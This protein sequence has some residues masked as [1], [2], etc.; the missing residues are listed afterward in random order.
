MSIRYMKDK[1]TA[2]KRRKNGLGKARRIIRRKFR[3]KKVSCTLLH[4]RRLILF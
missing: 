3:V 2:E 4:G 1:K